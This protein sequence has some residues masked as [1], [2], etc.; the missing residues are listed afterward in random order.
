[1]QYMITGRDIRIVPIDN[2]ET[3]RAHE[4]RCRSNHRE[5]GADGRFLGTTA[6]ETPCRTRKGG[7]AK[8]AGEWQ[9]LFVLARP[10]A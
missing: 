2:Q 10:V 7:A 1:M 4:R 3:R 5:R 9:R 8:P 6:A